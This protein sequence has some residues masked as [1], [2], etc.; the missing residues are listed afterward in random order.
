MTKKLNCFIDGDSL[1]IT[2]D[3]FVNLQESDAVFIDGLD[4]NKIEEIRWLLK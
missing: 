3:D 1:C 2:R 4:H